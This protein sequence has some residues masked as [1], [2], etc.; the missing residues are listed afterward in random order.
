[1]QRLA[2]CQP[3]LIRLLDQLDLVSQRCCDAFEGVQLTGLDPPF[4]DAVQG[5][6]GTVCRCCDDA[7]RFPGLADKP[8]TRSSII[9]GLLQEECKGKV[10]PTNLILVDDQDGVDQLFPRAMSYPWL[11]GLSG[12]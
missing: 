10:S 12:T 6:L 5:R 7:V 3:R 8:L 1:M 4:Q 11:S 2:G 9:T